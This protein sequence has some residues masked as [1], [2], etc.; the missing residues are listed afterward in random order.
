M[1]IANADTVRAIAAKSGHR[2]FNDLR[3][4]SEVA[5]PGDLKVREYLQSVGT[6]RFET[7]ASEVASDK[8]V[9]YLYI[10]PD[11][12]TACLHSLTRYNAGSEANPRY[13]WVGVTSDSFGAPTALS[14][15]HDDVMCKVVL[16]MSPLDMV[17]EDEWPKLEHLAPLNVLRAG[18]KG[19]GQPH[20]LKTLFFAGS[21]HTQTPHFVLLPKLF[22]VRVG[23]YLPIGLSLKNDSVGGEDGVQPPPGKSFPPGFELWFD[24]MKY[25]AIRNQGRSLNAPSPK[26]KI[27]Q[28][29]PQLDFLDEIAMGKI[30][31]DRLEKGEISTTLTQIFSSQDIY[32]A[33]QPLVKEAVDAMLVEWYSLLPEDFLPPPKRLKRI[34]RSS[35]EESKMAHVHGM[36]ADLSR[37]KIEIECDI[38]FPVTKTDG[39]AGF[40]KLCVG[41]NFTKKTCP[42]FGSKL[43]TCKLAHLG[44]C[45]DTISDD[46]LKGKVYEWVMNSQAIGFAPG[47]GPEPG[48]APS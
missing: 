4:P 28:A 40:A 34:T 7:L 23:Q 5:G 17:E 29:S 36:F 18:A 14:V 9:R 43:K 21:D 42:A 46:D 10:N 44:E 20:S 6:S 25:C 19:S 26:N 37:H 27:F 47:K 22:P 33:V 48:Y 12:Y 15:F 2:S 11:G 32:K 45:F 8:L 24:G 1:V 30:N 35:S 39:S 31:P 38:D 13:E 16:G 3:L 41:H